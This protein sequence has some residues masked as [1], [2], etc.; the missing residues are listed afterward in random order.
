MCYPAMALTTQEWMHRL[1]GIVLVSAI[2]QQTFPL[3]SSGSVWI[4]L[5]V[6]QGVKIQTET[7]YPL[8][9]QREAP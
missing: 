5:I 3:P 8:P 2:V 7:H 1:T 9:N 6:T 4:F